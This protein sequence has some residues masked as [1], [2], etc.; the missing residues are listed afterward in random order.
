MSSSSV[1]AALQKRVS[2]ELTTS[3]IGGDA[4]IAGIIGDSPSQYS[5]SPALWNA[6]F[7]HL[8]IS[9]LY[10]PFDVDGIHLGPLLAAL[11]DSEL[12]LGANVTVPHKVRVIDFLDELDDGA[13]RIGAVNTVVRTARGR[14]I[15]YNTD[16]DGFV[17]SL[18]TRQPDRSA[19]FIRSLRGMNVLLLGAGG[20]ARA[21][22]FHL[23]DLM[24]EGRLWISNRTF[25]HAASLG[26]EVEKNGGHA[27][28]I[29]EKEIPK[30][31]TQ[32]RL[33]INSTTKGQGGVRK[34]SGNKVLCLEPYSA[35]APADP[36]AFVESE[37]GKAG[38]S[39][40]WPA[41][42]RADIDANLSASMSLAGSIPASA[43]FYDLIYHPEE[44][45]FLRH[46]RLTGHSTM[47]GKAMIVNQA[48]IAFCRRICT[49]EL[50]LRG[51]DTPETYQ[52]ILEVMYHAW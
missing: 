39:G 28:A 46:G 38:S 22:A 48:V 42:A 25:E 13:K 43:A 50:S 1:I 14:L 19:S 44:T 26:A 29:Q 30:Y 5:K 10:L 47:N 16:G 9:A 15:G 36:P 51:L 52:R 11:K 41:A 27:V 49:A 34:L 4:A 33:I 23:A 31:A 7:R 37:L 17:E 12:F 18:L 2:N 45:V 32:A 6:A 21:V 24:G 8:G 40:E 35:L 20:S 3:A